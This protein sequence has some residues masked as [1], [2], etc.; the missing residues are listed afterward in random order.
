ME[1]VNPFDPTS[2][3][4][5]EIVPIVMNLF[6]N[7]MS[8]SFSDFMMMY[9]MI[10]ALINRDNLIH[11]RIPF[12]DV[13]FYVFGINP[14]ILESDPE[15]FPLL[16]SPYLLYAVEEVKDSI[17]YGIFPGLTDAFETLKDVMVVPTSKV[18]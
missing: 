16:K 3:E 15:R 7:S 13:N 9:L 4:Q 6:G 10:G 18:H 5:K 2:E 12:G 17:T 14:N 1:T 8:C 11:W